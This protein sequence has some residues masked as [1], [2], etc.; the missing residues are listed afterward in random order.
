MRNTTK[1][2]ARIF[3]RLIIPAVFTIMLSLPAWCQ[4]IDDRP[5]RERNMSPGEMMWMHMGMWIIGLVWIAVVLGSSCHSLRNWKQQR[6]RFMTDTMCFKLLTRPSSIKWTKLGFS[7]LLLALLGAFIWFINIDIVDECSGKKDPEGL[8][9]MFPLF[10]AIYIMFT[11]LFIGSLIDY[12]TSHICLTN[13]GISK[14]SLIYNPHPTLINWK[15]IVSVEVHRDPALQSGISKL[16]V[17]GSLRYSNIVI[18]GHHPQLEQILQHIREAVPDKLVDVVAPPEQQRN[19]TRHQVVN[20][21]LG[22]AITAWVICLQPLLFPVYG[23]PSNWR[24]FVTTIWVLGFGMCAV[25]L[26]VFLMNVK[27]RWVSFQTGARC[28]MLT[29][30]NERARAWLVYIAAEAIVVTLAVILNNKAPSNLPFV[31][32]TLALVVVMSAILG[33]LKLVHI[34]TTRFCL[35]EDEVC[36]KSLVAG[37]EETHIKW[38]LLS[39]VDVQ[40]SLSNPNRIKKVVLNTGPGGPYFKSI[41]ISGRHAYIDSILRDIR[42]QA[43]DKYGITPDRFSKMMPG[44]ELPIGSPGIAAIYTILA[45]DFLVMVAYQSYEFLMTLVMV[46]C[47][48]MYSIPA[49]FMLIKML[50][51]LIDGVKNWRVRRE[52]LASSSNCYRISSVMI[53]KTSAS[54]LLVAYELCICLVVYIIVV[55]YSADP[56]GRPSLPFH[57]MMLPMYIAAYVMLAVMMPIDAVF[58]LTAHYCITDLGIGIEGAVEGW[59]RRAMRWDE[60]TQVELKYDEKMPLEISS[61]VLKCGTRKQPITIS[62]NH[63]DV[64]TILQDIREH[65]PEYFE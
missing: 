18:P 17:K 4:S 39:S 31:L 11:T 27:S 12:L 53:G 41:T 43:P 8:Y 38:D 51:T 25:R 22:L 7:V 5:C 1:H 65:A 52:H 58:S 61:I 36:L 21:T 64:K 63:P 57:L 9:S 48:I 44:T 2:I 34:L 14:E 6:A 59:N 35:A 32:P 13:I 10:L 3:T 42:E 37:A 23:S 49:C 30:G 20:W 55:L 19:T 28:Y 16:V 46:I 15:Q 26:I 47:V 33:T 50:G 60:L 54:L 45:A 62:G 56:N 29:S 40:Y 24:L